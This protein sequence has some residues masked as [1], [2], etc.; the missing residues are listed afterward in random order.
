MLTPLI[1]ILVDE[2][3]IGYDS[4]RMVVKIVFRIDKISNR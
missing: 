2:I 4:L 1:I 3:V